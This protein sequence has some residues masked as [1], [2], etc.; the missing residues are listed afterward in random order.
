LEISKKNLLK[1]FESL[2]QSSGDL[3]QS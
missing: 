3:W 2:Q 1:M